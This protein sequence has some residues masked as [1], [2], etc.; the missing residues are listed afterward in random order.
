[1]TN[2]AWYKEEK[3]L[4]GNNGPLVAYDDYTGEYEKTFNSYDDLR[5]EWPAAE[6]TGY[7]MQAPGKGCIVYC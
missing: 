7:E 6:I 5:A 4:Y 1:M 3:A 2:A